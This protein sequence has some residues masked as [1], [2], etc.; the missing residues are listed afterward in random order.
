MTST[1]PTK[2]D[3]KAALK[4]RFEKHVDRT[5]MCWLW[6]A[7]TKGS[8]NR[9]DVGGGKHMQA[10]YW[11]WKDFYN[12]AIPEPR[13]LKR[14][15]SSR[16]CVRPTHYTLREPKPQ[17]GADEQDQAAADEQPV[18]PEAVIATAGSVAGPEPTD[19]AD[20]RL[21]AQ[22]FSLLKVARESQAT[23]DAR[24]GALVGAIKHQAAELASLQ[25]N[26]DGMRDRIDQAMSTLLER[27][28]PDPRPAMARLQAEIRAMVP[29]TAPPPPP[30]APQPE[31]ELPAERDLGALLQVAFVSVVGPHE[32]WTGGDT[33]IIDDE[34]SRALRQSGGDNVAATRLFGNWLSQYHDQTRGNGGTHHP[35]TPRGFSSWLSELI[36]R[37]FSPMRTFRPAPQVGDDTLD[38]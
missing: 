27:E 6:D 13:S 5:D 4:A 15:C 1:K 2:M 9:F 36:D 21:S 33:R 11:A 12:S 19:D 7:Y 20:T 23:A 28:I 34:F 16:N 17:V 14:L 35:T 22:L 25:R 30:L 32:P 10:H 3:S 38:S 8:G 29:T 26:V 18:A 31:P 37:E 24:Y